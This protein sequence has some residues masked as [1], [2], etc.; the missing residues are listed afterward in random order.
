MFFAVLRM[1]WS[2]IN[3]IVINLL[4]QLLE[5]LVFC[6]V[7]SISVIVQNR[8]RID[9]IQKTNMASMVDILKILSP[10]RR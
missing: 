5:I 8:I 1:V 3:I 10:L 2:V 6:I 9:A 7:F 4:A